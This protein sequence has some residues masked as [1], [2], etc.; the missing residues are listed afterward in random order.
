[1][2]GFQGVKV[3]ELIRR[4]RVSRSRRLG[5]IVILGCFQS[6]KAIFY[7]FEACRLHS[8]NRS[9]AQFCRGRVLPVCSLVV[10]SSAREVIYPPSPPPA[11]LLE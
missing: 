4:P 8:V 5:S 6:C 7:L 2:Q 11:Q 1:M 9:V 3:G 10:S